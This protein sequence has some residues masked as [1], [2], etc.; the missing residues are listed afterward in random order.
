MSTDVAQILI[1]VAVTLVL[2]G[3]A[4]LEFL[5]RWK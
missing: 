3:W 4:L 1:A 5:K 2:G